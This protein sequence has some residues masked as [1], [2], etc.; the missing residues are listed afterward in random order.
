MRKI[1][2]SIG[3]QLNRQQFL[4]VLHVYEIFINPEKLD[5]ILYLK[6]G[7]AAL[8][9]LEKEKINSIMQNDITIFSNG[10]EGTNMV[11]VSANWKVPT[12]IPN[13]FL[14]QLDF[15]EENIDSTNIDR[16]EMLKK[17]CLSSRAK[18]GYYMG[19]DISYQASSHMIRDKDDIPENQ[20]NLPILHSPYMFGLDFL[21][22]PFLFNG[23]TIGM[24]TMY[25]QW[26]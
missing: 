9:E 3:P 19:D 7:V 24:L 2:T 10:K 17:I 22:Y 20:F 25:S 13:N 4:D 5:Y 15:E 12:H 6:N 26:V 8:D 16:Y 11:T 23:L 21:L 1:I 18:I 14:A